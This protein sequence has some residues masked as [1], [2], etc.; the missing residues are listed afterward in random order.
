M[1]FSDI[2][3]PRSEVLRKE[4]LEGVIDIQNL[5]DQKKRFIEARPED[6]FSLTFPTTDVKIALGN[7]HQRFNSTEKSA[8]LFLLEGFKG[9]GKSHLE[10]LVYHLFRNAQAGQQWL[11]QHNLKCSLPQ[12]AIV[13]IHKFTDFPLDSIWSLVFD[14]LDIDRKENCHKLPNLDELRQ[15]LAGKRLVL[16]LDE[17]ELGVQSIANDHIRAQNLSFL[18]MLSEEGLRSDSASV[19]I[20]ASVYDANKEPGS[21]LK[22]VPRV[23]IKFSEPLDRQQ[24]VLHRLFSNARNLDRNKVETVVRSYVNAWKKAGIPTDERYFDKFVHSYPFTP[25]LLEMLLQRVLRRDF[26]GNRGPLGLLGSVVRNT[27]KKADVISAAHLDITDNGIRNRLVDLDPGQSLLQCAQSDLRIL[28]SQPYSKEI[29]SA[30]LFATLTSSGNV[31]GLSEQ[32][33]TTQVLKPSDDQNV[34]QST[35]QALERFGSYFQHA[36]GNYL[37]DTQEKPYAKVEYHALKVDPGDAREFAL[38]RWRTNVFG[39]TTAVVF[40]DSDQ[41]RHSLAELDKN[42][43]RFVLAPRRLSG[44]DRLQIFHG[45]ENR[46]QIILLEPKSETFNALDHADLVK[47]A[48]LA[49]AASEL[50]HSTNEADRKRQYEKIATDNIKY[51]DEA[52]K[53]AGL[54]YLS[55]H[56]DSGDPGNIQ[57]ELDP[58]GTGVT[59]QDVL[60]QLQQQY[61]P[62][63][64][65]EDHISESLQDDRRK[66]FIEK[67]FAE[68]KATY[69]KTIGFPVFTAE[70]IL[71]QAVTRLCKDRR[72]G[73]K[74]S[75]S[76]HCGSAPGYSGSEWN[77]VFVVEP[78]VEEG[79]PSA[80]PFPTSQPS[81][82]ATPVSTL[83]EGGSE[84]PLPEADETVVNIQTP[85]EPA[86]NQLRQRVAERLSEY[87][88]PR[89]HRARFVVY[90]QNGSV[91]LSTLPSAIRGT[92]TGLGEI[93]CEISIEKQ[94]SFNKA[95]IEQM[96]EQI[97]SFSGA[98][99]RADLKG[100]AKATTD[101]SAGQ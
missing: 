93:D 5:Q 40:R 9:S 95:Q 89:I 74:N 10:L 58:L 63:Q 101:S 38:N 32:D 54:Y 26:Q 2:V 22:R 44:T 46:N 71:I 27:H 77:D 66:L 53:K 1:S 4:G 24:V 7:L 76:K 28:E 50:V 21:T 45:A 64:R 39:D 23:D 92:L 15:A 55:M 100:T 57:F 11:E 99:Y 13:V 43:L 33:L 12:D 31:R 87:E 80:L 20:F 48:Q 18:Q 47:W 61:Y 82:A 51:I 35:L 37:F 84:P 79:E 67:T 29:V 49:K 97:P 60:L 96:V 81:P 3:S 62:A 78:F 98:Y 69:R 85:N 75:R 30:V 70:T 65:F 25:E 19:T 88:E 72:I 16:I 73:L 83:G 59:R 42:S 17:L 56:V 94:G 36:E 68:I 14:G 6:F 8:G 41:A 86:I 91:E 52:F 34:Y 90:L